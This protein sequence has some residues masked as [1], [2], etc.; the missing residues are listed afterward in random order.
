MDK[1]ILWQTQY[2]YNILTLSLKEKDYLDSHLQGSY[3]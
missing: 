3:R 1:K 2:M